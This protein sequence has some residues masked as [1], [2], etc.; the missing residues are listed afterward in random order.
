[1]SRPRQHVRRILEVIAA[2]VAV[3]ILAIAGNLLSTGLTS[4]RSGG[5]AVGSAPASGTEVGQSR[6]DEVGADAPQDVPQSVPDGTQVVRTIDLGL[7]VA[8][9]P[10][11]AA[12]AR[13]VVGGYNGYVST[14]RV[15]SRGYGTITARIPS[16]STD[17]ALEALTALGTL[18]SRTSQADD[19]SGTLSDIEARVSAQRASLARLTDL[20]GRA[21]SVADVS[22]VEKEITRRQ[23][24][25]DALLARQAR[26]ADKVAMST[27][28]L[29]LSG[30]GAA[31]QDPS[32]WSQLWQRVGGE[33]A[34]SAEGLIVLVAVLA[35]YA[36]LVGVGWWAV[37]L[38]RRRVRR[39]R[40]SSGQGGGK[41]PGGDD[42]APTL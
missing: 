22:A 14:E 7:E 15:T 2:L 39:A 12:R 33:L 3:A 24:D 21:G 28:T 9:V 41:A 36:L 4:A 6:P 34:N 19:V 32:R 11:A 18:Q 25:L 37:R 31:A 40:E 1:M 10:D 13:T 17:A 38:I 27:V 26:L 29:T 20:M 5:V 23:A 8:S 42:T 16:V 30:P 35:P